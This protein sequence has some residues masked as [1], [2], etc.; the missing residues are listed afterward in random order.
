[1]ECTLESSNDLGAEG[2]AGQ[3]AHA[4]R[5]LLDR[6][7]YGFQYAVLKRAQDLALSGMSQ[8]QAEASEFPTEVREKPTHIDFVLKHSKKEYLLVSECKRANPALA[9][10]CFTKAPFRHRNHDP[11]ALVC[12]KVER[13]LDTHYTSTTP[14]V[15]AHH[16]EVYHIGLEVRTNL[17]GDAEGGGD[18][19]I[20]KAVA[21][22]LRGVNG[23]TDLMARHHYLVKPSGTK[24]L[25]GAVFTTATL[26][27]TDAK[28]DSANIETGKLSD[29]AEVRKLPWL[30]FDYHQ[31]PE[32]KHSLLEGGP[33][34]DLSNFLGSHYARTV[35]IV[36]SEGIDDFLSWSSNQ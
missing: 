7:G 35:C 21:Q 25:I 28:L 6:H 17:K 33:S 11:C 23:L 22:V 9:N 2:K 15:W 19:A 29:S 26:W 5:K 32:L 12:D 13:I 36:A 10:W 8:W 30:A 27:V 24:I 1:M 16:S 14:H 31:S 20:Q 3:V 18:D 34:E 4:F